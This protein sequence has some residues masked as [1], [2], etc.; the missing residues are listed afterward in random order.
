MVDMA[1]DPPP[2]AAASAEL[3]EDRPLAASP[4]SAPGATPTEV[5]NEA[6]APPGSDAAPSFLSARS[7]SLQN[8]FA[9]ASH[10]E[11]ATPAVGSG[12][13]DASAADEILRLMDPAQ[14]F[15]RRTSESPPASVPKE[16]MRVKPTSPTP[17]ATAGDPVK[18]SQQQAPTKQ[19]SAQQRKLQEVMR[20]AGAGGAGGGE[21]E[22]SKERRYLSFKCS[23]H[24][25][26]MSCEMRGEN[27]SL[28]EV[29]EGI[30]ENR[31]EALRLE[32]LVRILSARYVAREAAHSSAEGRPFRPPPT[33][34]DV[35]ETEMRE[36][37]AIRAAVN[38]GGL[39]RKGARASTRGSKSRTSPL[40]DAEALLSFAAT[41]SVGFSGMQRRLIADNGDLLVDDGGLDDQPGDWLPSPPDY[42]GA[43]QGPVRPF[44][45]QDPTPFAQTGQ[46]PTHIVVVEPDGR[47]AIQAAPPSLP[48]PPPLPPTSSSYPTFPTFPT[49][50]QLPPK[51]PR[52]NPTYFFP[53]LPSPLMSP[54]SVSAVAETRAIAL[55]VQR[56]PETLEA[57]RRVHEERWR[58]AV[59]EKE[60]DE[61]EA[62]TRRRRES[63]ARVVRGEDGFFYTPATADGAETAST[64]PPPPSDEQLQLAQSVAAAWAAMQQDP[65]SAAEADA[66]PSGAPSA[67]ALDPSA[68]A[69]VEPYRPLRPLGESD[70]TL[71][72]LAS[73]TSSAVSRRP[74][75]FLLSPSTPHAPLVAANASSSG[76]AA[77]PTLSLDAAGAAA[78][79]L[80]SQYSLLRTPSAGALLSGLGVGGP[81]AGAGA[82][83][84][85][86]S[87]SPLTGLRS[88]YPAFGFVED[89]LRPLGVGA[90]GLGGGGA[91]GVERS[92]LE[93]LLGLGGG[94]E[95]EVD[96][97]DERFEPQ[98]EKR[99]AGGK[100]RERVGDEQQRKEHGQ[101][102][103]DRFEPQLEK[104]RTS[105]SSPRG[106]ESAAAALGDG[107][108]AMDVE[109]DLGAASDDGARSSVAP[110]Q[111]ARSASGRS[112]KGD[113]GDTA[114]D[115][116]T[117]AE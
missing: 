14:V 43:P 86:I 52:P 45:T 85:R 6:G 104:R 103:W 3:Q 48:V 66:A 111:S 77:R 81:A 16:Q 72:P 9:G 106:K 47:V 112:M 49:T 87:L 69:T 39:G 108:D 53:L 26:C 11:G 96:S 88:A 61:V 102:E 23:R 20:R 22:V 94:A 80:L 58:A 55:A 42:H 63:E 28:A 31:V 46:R 15:S 19:A 89:G 73:L 12:T 41:P 8:D 30:N 78:A 32:R 74:S 17:R 62:E 110:S 34:T 99:A 76:S 115:D 1:V 13:A 107:D 113:D 65:P 51:V 90:A 36:L 56:A 50:A 97:G 24:A 2:P 75:L 95:H 93:E 92:A 82:G 101:D 100:E 18:G 25:V 91:G 7:P 27:R 117:D 29:Q 10:P 38:G 114:S 83:G 71:A 116:E 59:R 5:E 105:P 44:I 70:P 21:F 60:R 40:E 33:M 67:P 64:A 37:E 4:A 84:R 54:R 79:S 98:V 109:T 68:F 57:R 35:I